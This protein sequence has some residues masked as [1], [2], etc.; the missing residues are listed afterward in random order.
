MNTDFRSDFQWPIVET[1]KGKIRGYFEK[2]VYKFKG[3]K[4]ADAKRYCPPVEVRPWDG[5]KECLA[6]GR[7][8]PTIE[9]KGTSYERL[10]ILT[11]YRWMPE[12]ENCQF[13]NIWTE[14][15]DETAKKPVMVWLHGGG[16][17]CGSSI[18]FTAY[19]AENL[20]KDGDVV[21]VSLNHRLNILGFLDISD[22]GEQYHNSGNLGME[23]IVAALRWVQKNISRFGG[24]P[25]NVT[26]FGQSGG[27][28]K[29]TALM[30][31][32]EAAGLFHKVI[33]QS[34]V[35]SNEVFRLTPEKS[36]KVGRA[37]VNELGGIDNL[38]TCRFRDIS[39]AFLKVQPELWEKERL[40]EWAPVENGWY[41]GDPLCVGPT[42]KFKTTPAIVGSCIAETLMWEGKYYDATASEEEKIKYIR[43]RYGEHTPAMIK[44]FKKA[45]PDKDILNLRYL[46]AEFRHN[47]L[48]YLDKRSEV[49][50]A[51]TYS[52]MIAYN[53]GFNGGTPAYHACE[54]ALVFRSTDCMAIMQ[55]PGIEQLCN[56]ISM[57]WSNFAH[58][59]DPNNSFLPEKWQPYKAGDEHTFVYDKRSWCAG[60]NDAEMYEYMQKNCPVHV[61]PFD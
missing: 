24:D 11:E 27:G 57:S 23:D 50:E 36:R 48:K 61:S 30:Q 59:G 5:V 55:E 13:L 26:I 49:C 52:Y 8:A 21:V 10:G 6:Y 56:E 32:P 39:D 22:Y 34:G 44:L 18:E 19:E 2:G 46:D 14:R 33:V 25:D 7:V 38:L 37:V 58:T 31:I 12:D 41:V 54:H 29:C 9:G 47:I 51:P 3:I 15:I 43:E 45:Y 17:F 4:Y 20:C 16:Y 42:E 35:N 28:M 53:F 40:G 1:D 60:R